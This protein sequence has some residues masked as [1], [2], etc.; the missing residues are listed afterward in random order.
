[1]SKI[2]NLASATGLADEWRM[3]LGGR[4]SAN[5]PPPY[6][7][8]DAGG[9]GLADA[10]NGPDQSTKIHPQPCMTWAIELPWPP[11]GN[12][13]TRHSK[14]R[15]YKTQA[16]N[17]YRA[18]VAQIVRAA[19]SHTKDLP[20]TGPLEVHWIASPPDRR[21]RDCDNARKEAAD[22]LTHAGLWVDDSNK[23]IPRETWT[24]TDPSPN[25]HLF[26]T[27]LQIVTTANQRR[28]K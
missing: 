2:N 5:P 25:G 28:E 18:A 11:T 22:A 4:S 13:A 8:A 21:P 1:M 27:V 3:K 15:H 24:W 17:T 9:R 16:S 20:L 26:A 12:T 10:Q 6:K 23:V 7:V 14:G 19:T